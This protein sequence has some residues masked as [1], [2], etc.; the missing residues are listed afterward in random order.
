M[1]VAKKNT[2]LTRHLYRSETNKVI[3]G[4]AGGLGEYF[5]IDPVIVRVIFVVLTFF[6]GGGILL[7]LILWLVIPKESDLG[8]DHGEVIK[9]N[10][11]EIKSKARQFTSDLK[12]EKGKNNSREIM[13]F[14]LVLLGLVFLLDNFGFYVADFVWKLW[15]VLLIIFGYMILTKNER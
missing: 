10:A 11:D 14:I 13:G 5:D 1:P 15:P 2:Q 9:G 6:G 3:A 4:V 8:S 12:T 7:Y